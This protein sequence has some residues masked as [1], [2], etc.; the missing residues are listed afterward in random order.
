MSDHSTIAGPL[1]GPAKMLENLLLVEHVSKEFPMNDGT[2]FAA[3]R[4][5]TLTIQ[6]IEAK[7]QIVSL[8]G[9][10]GAGKTT[11]LRIIAALDRPTSGQVLITNGDGQAMRPVQVGDVGVVF[12]RYPLF[13]DLNVL[14]NLIEPAVRSGQSSEAAKSKALRYLDE[15]GMVK[16]GLAWPLQLSGGQRQ[17]V[18]IMQQLMLERHFIIL[19][20]PFSGLDPVNIINVINM[21]GRI[22]HEHTLNTF[23]I[24]TH[25]VTSALAISDHVYLLGRE[26][27]AQGE[28]LPGS[29]VMKEYDLIAEGLAYR[30]D[31]EDLPRFA[32]L[33]KEIKLVEFPKL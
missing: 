28:L 6:N 9:P 33:R 27:N 5:F 19:D 7:P 29:R 12:Q 3:L 11:A 4:D 8:L 1:A 15:F 22:A 25:D 26:R 31:I 21:I 16:Q 2:T 10:S 20:E 24:I 14:N 13:D 17:R 23:I 32:E 30:P 18:A